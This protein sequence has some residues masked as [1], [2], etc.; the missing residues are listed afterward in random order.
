MHYDAPWNHPRAAPTK[1][2]RITMNCRPTTVSTGRVKPAYIMAEPDTRRVTAPATAPM[3]KTSQPVPAP[4]EQ[5]T[6]PAPAPRDQL[7]QPAPPPH[8]SAPS[9]PATLTPGPVEESAFQPGLTYEHPSPQGVIWDHELTHNSISTQTILGPFE[10]LDQ[11]ILG[12]F[13]GLTQTQL[14]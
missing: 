11:K 9:P 2:L 13:E 5:S 8:S 6:Q 4:R 14:H 7:T 10:S 1:T 3:D 12:P